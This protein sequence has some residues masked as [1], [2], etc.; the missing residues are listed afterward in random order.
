MKP[1]H[2]Y[3]FSDG[4]T[5]TLGPED[6]HDLLITPLGVLDGADENHV[7]LSRLVRQEWPDDLTE[8]ERN[9]SLSSFLQAGGSA[10][11]LTLEVRRREGDDFVQYIV[12]RPSSASAATPDIP[13]TVGEYTYQVTADEV[14]TAESAAE[15]FV[16]YF[17]HDAV[18][19]DFTLRLLP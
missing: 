11:A 10:E 9:E 5:I 19:E 2:L 4:D 6:D 17:E 14:F 18:P 8:D 3:E 7:I 15:V 16:H 13:I 12:G 1:T